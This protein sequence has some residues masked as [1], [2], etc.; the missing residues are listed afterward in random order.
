MRHTLRI[1]AIGALAAALLAGGAAQALASAEQDD[2]VAVTDA[3]QTGPD[4]HQVT[5]LPG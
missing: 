3:S 2:P 4:D 5:G 1:T